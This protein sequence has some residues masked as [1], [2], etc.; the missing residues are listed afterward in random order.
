MQAAEKEKKGNVEVVSMHNFRDVNV[1][2][3]RVIWF[4]VV[5]IM[6]RL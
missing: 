1:S 6:D 4:A 3:F 5:Q 2:V